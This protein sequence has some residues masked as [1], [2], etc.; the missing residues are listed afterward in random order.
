MKPRPRRLE[1]EEEDEYG[2]REEV[3]AKF[4]GYSSVEEKRA[5]EQQMIE[6]LKRWE[7]EE[8]RRREEKLEAQREL[9]DWDYDDL[10]WT[11]EGGRR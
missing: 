2:I 4:Y 11:D 6:D 9:D 7:L 5:H 3:D 1:P 8:E 10:D